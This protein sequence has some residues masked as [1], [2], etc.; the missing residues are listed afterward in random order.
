[1]KLY[2]HWRSSCTYR[3]RI[4]LAL[5]AL[6]Y[7]VRT[8]DLTKGAQHEPAFTRLNPMMQVPVLEVSPGG[9]YLHQSV[10]IMEY[11]EECYPHPPLLPTDPAARAQVRALTEIINAGTQPLQNARVLAQVKAWGGDARAHAQGVIRRGLS[12]FSAAR[13]EPA[14]SDA[15][16]F[17]YGDTPTMADCAL[18]PQL[19]NAR[20]FGLPVDTWPE[21]V[22]IEART[23]ALPALA[24][25]QPHQQ[26]DAPD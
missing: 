6:P 21:L 18:I 12:A 9:P 5:K 11:L 26:P 23:L 1:M 4:A 24:A 13:G 2:G 3:V 8:V 19:E 17:S 20:R 16:R 14:A 25:V 22:A 10:A 15:G 7:D